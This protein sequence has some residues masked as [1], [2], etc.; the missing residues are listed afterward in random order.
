MKP[1][2]GFAQTQHRKPEPLSSPSQLNPTK[3][4]ENPCHRINPKND[5]L[6][7]RE[8]KGAANGRAFFFALKEPAMPEFAVTPDT[9]QRCCYIEPNGAQSRNRALRGPLG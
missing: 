7:E 8:E 2:A 6:K 3:E 9:P 4:K 5:K 1:V